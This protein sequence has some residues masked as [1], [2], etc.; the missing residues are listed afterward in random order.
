MSSM[1]LNKLKGTSINIAK[2]LLHKNQLERDGFWQARDT[3]WVEVRV[4][5]MTSIIYYI[6]LLMKER[7]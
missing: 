6:F 3:E 5:E 4:H 2:E 1:K 7:F